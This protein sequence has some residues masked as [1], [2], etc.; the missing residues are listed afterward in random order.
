MAGY[1]RMDF[2]FFKEH[3]IYILPTIIIYKNK[4]FKGVEISFKFLRLNFYVTISYISEENY[5]P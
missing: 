2:S 1:I 3:S 4:T 5:E